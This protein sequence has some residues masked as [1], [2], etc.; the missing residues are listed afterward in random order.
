MTKPGDTKLHDRWRR[1]KKE[2][3]LLSQNGVKAQK[4]GSPLNLGE[5]M[6]P[7]NVCGQQGRRQDYYFGAHLGAVYGGF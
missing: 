6:E 3:S 4:H 5:K 7:Y 1:E 2:I